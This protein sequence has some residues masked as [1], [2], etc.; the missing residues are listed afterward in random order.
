[1]ME[2]LIFISLLIEIIVT[3]KFLEFLSSHA[4]VL[5][6]KTIQKHAKI[7]TL[8]GYYRGIRKNIHF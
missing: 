7:I 3:F 8:Y 4:T 5:N 1:M 2:Q 6:Y